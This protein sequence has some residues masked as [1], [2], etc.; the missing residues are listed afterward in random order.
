MDKTSLYHVFFLV[1]VFCGD[2]KSV[3]KIKDETVHKNTRRK[4]NFPHLCLLLPRTKHSLPRTDFVVI[5]PVH[6]ILMLNR[7]PS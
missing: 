1:N 3:F 4:V 7:G 5:I 6:F 2:C